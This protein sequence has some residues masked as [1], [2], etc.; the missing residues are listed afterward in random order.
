VR[1]AE[2]A[3]AP[4]AR[5]HAAVVAANGSVYAIGGWNTSS[6]V[7]YTAIDRYDPRDN[8][9]RV[10]AT[11]P[12]A[13]GGMAAGV[14]GTTIVLVGG[15]T[16]DDPFATSVDRYDVVARRWSNGAPLPTPRSATATA[17]L[18]RRLY[19]IGGLAMTNGR[20]APTSVVESYDVETNTWR[21]ELPLPIPISYAG[22]ATVDGAIY[23]TGGFS[24]GE[25]P[26]S[27]SWMYLPAKATSAPGR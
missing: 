8:R 14:V 15:W 7:H 2:D 4:V 18:G 12:R 9:W 5:C 17:V 23:V 19:V 10:D 22:A 21:R 27:S 25:A 16:P 6:T 20:L 24:T 11:L 26:E 13:R 3:A 1:R